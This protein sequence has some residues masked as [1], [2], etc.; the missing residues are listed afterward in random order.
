MTP[1]LEESYL[2]TVQICDLKVCVL[3]TF[4]LKHFN[5]SFILKGFTEQLYWCSVATNL[6][7]QVFPHGGRFFKTIKIYTVSKVLGSYQGE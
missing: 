4:L 1:S 3:L 2:T 7:I 5:I 6:Q